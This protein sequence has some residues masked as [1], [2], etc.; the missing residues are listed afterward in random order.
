HHG[1]HAD[2]GCRPERFPEHHPAAGD[3]G[4]RLRARLAVVPARRTRTSVRTSRVAAAPMGLMSLLVL[5][6]VFLEANYAYVATMLGAVGL[7]ALVTT[8]LLLLR[9]H[10]ADETAAATLCAVVVLGTTLHVSFGLP[11]ADR[12]AF[13]LRELLL[14][15]CGVVTPT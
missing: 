15:T 1:A 13:E 2:A 12:G 9:D 5:R 7:A 10:P 4:R 8:G 14:T 6:P 3:D 11:G